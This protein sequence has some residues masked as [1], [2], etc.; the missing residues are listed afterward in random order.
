MSSIRN[1]VFCA[2]AACSGAAQA[3]SLPT[4][5]LSSAPD[6]QG[7]PGDVVS[8]TI[9]LQGNQQTYEV[10]E[11]VRL[12]GRW[13]TVAQLSSTARTQCTLL[14]T[15]DTVKVFATTGTPNAPITH[16]EA[17]TTRFDHV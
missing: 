2:F 8:V 11:Y 15:G 5:S 17:R 7:A 1:L 16:G 6:A 12:D 4:P 10:L 9:T 3:Q 13:F 14:S